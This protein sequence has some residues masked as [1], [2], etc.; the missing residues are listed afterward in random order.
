MRFVKMHG[1]GN[2]F[3]V[4]DGAKE[5][6]PDDHISNVARNACDRHLGVGADGII[7]VLPSRVANFRMRMFNPD[8]SEAEMCGN[9]I[10]CFAKYVFDR[11][12]HT[13]PILTVETLGGVKTLK[14]NT[15]GG[16]V[17]TARVDMGEPKLLRS[18]IPMKGGNTQVV[19][20]TLKAAGKKLEITCVSMGNPHCVTFV[21]NVDNY[22]VEK[23]GPEVENH[24]SFP[25]RTNV[26]FV[27]IVSRD[28]LRMR[29]WERGAGETLA[30]GT[31][32]CASAVAAMLND[33]VSR[34]VTV[35]LLGGD[36]FIEWMGDNR[37]FMTGPVE[38]VFDGKGN[39]SVYR[40]WV[41]GDA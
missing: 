18:E 23:I 6:V 16:K 17:Q 30:C 34:K 22:S 7:L 41:S 4:I 32:A 1:A 38:E 29:V 27:E 2:D 40:K 36:L 37:V 31:G 39:S 12:M 11:K 20:E 15:S 3:V 25:R 5:P 24:P 9:G 13:D 8:G 26:E 21:D 10:R 33:K 28:E 35:H 19:G 14:L